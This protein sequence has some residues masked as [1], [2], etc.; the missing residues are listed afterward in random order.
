MTS[1]Q[2]MGILP[3]LAACSAPGKDAGAKSDLLRGSRFPDSCP[4]DGGGGSLHTSPVLVAVAVRIL[5]EQRH[6]ETADLHRHK[7]PRVLSLRSAIIGKQL[8]SR[9]PLTDTWAQPIRTSRTNTPL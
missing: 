2:V 5:S 8:T 1:V 6:Q 3:R 4:G 7:S 9:H